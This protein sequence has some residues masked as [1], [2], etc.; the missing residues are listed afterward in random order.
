MTLLLTAHDVLAQAND[1][2]I[3]STG[4]AIAF[5]IFGPIALG[6]ALGMVFARHAV[7][8]ALLLALTMF[9]LAILYVIQQAPFLGSRRSSSTPAP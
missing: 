2:G 3:T 5:R 4:E 1:A 6:A 8:C 7:H 9:S